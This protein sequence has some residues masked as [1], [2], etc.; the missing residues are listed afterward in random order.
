M[1]KEFDCTHLAALRRV[2]DAAHGR[3]DDNVARL[4]TR[5][6]RLLGL[7]EQGEERKRRKVVAGRVDSVRV[8]PALKRLVVDHLGRHLLGRRSRCEG[9]PAEGH[10]VVVDQEVDVRLLRGDRVPD[11]WASCELTECSTK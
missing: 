11:L 4:A 6:G 10:A 1:K 3:H 9:R 7:T 2:G 8:C 5:D